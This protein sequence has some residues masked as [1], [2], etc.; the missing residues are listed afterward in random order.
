MVIMSVTM[1]SSMLLLVSIA[2]ARRH[3]P[4]DAS[5]ALVPKSALVHNSLAA[6]TK[7]L[8]CAVKALALEY[9][10]SLLTAPFHSRRNATAAVRSSL[11][12]SGVCGLPAVPMEA[13]TLTAAA[14]RFFGAAGGASV[15]VSP[16][17]SDGNSGAS[18]TS[19]LKTLHAA[20][21]AART[22]GA[23]TTVYLAA[24]Q[25]NLASAEEGGTLRLDQRDSEIAWSSMAG[26]EGVG[27]IISG[28]R[29]LGNLKWSPLNAA[30]C[31]RHGLHCAGDDAAPIF[32][33]TLPSDVESIAELS[34]NGARQVRIL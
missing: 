14:P 32:K 24:G 8:D 5:G 7:E 31:I 1:T 20:Q 17:G 11:D 16:T 10:T 18:P 2:T 4:R 6:P 9:A 3:A 26:E 22:H 23:G 34:L 27:P 15:Y 21:R 13:P 19:A 25:Y 12:P 28:G 30:E 33:A 29:A